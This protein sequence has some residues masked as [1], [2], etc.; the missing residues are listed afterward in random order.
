MRRPRSR[1]TCRWN[2]LAAAAGL[3][4]HNVQGEPGQIADGARKL[5]DI[6]A[7]RRKVLKGWKDGYRGSYRYV[8]TGKADTEAAKWAQR[9]RKAGGAVAFNQIA[10]VEAQARSI[11]EALATF[12]TGKAAVI[13]RGLKKLMN[14][15]ENVNVSVDNAIRVSTFKALVESGMSDANAASAAKNLTV[16]F[17]RKGEWGPSLNALFSSPTP[18][19]KGGPSWCGR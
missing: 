1:I 19:S 12:K 7:I 18:R 2:H 17:N 15:V 6:K 13:K 8:T 10:D 9:F 14:S 4:L 5:Q 3:A 16:N 11:E